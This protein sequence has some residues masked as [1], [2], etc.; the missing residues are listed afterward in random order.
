E[1]DG[2]PDE[3]RTDRFTLREGNLQITM[4]S[5]LGLT[6]QCTRCH[7]HK[8]EPLTHEEYYQLQAVRYPAYCPER[9][10]AP[11]DRV[12]SI[13]SQA[14]R[15]PEYAAVRDQVRKAIVEREKEKPKPLET[16]AV[17]VETDPKPPV[18]HLLLRGQHNAPGKEVQ[19]G[20]PAIL[21]GPKNTFEVSP[22]P[23]G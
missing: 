11:K 20:V 5:L 16:I 12:V 23:E 15:F 21:C 7:D 19:P 6:I 1:S 17:F 18:H 13:A 9:W 8:F 2:N 22:R 3:V 10:T 4:N 14:K